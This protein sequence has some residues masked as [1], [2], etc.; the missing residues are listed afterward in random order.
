MTQTHTSKFIFTHEYLFRPF[1]LCY[2]SDRKYIVNADQP[3]L[4]IFR[5]NLNHVNCS[6]R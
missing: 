3:D 1:Y 4:I 2:N 5:Y 6:E